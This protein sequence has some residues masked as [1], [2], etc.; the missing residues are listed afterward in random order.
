MRQTDKEP[1][2]F[3]R[4][5]AH[6]SNGRCHLGLHHRDSLSNSFPASSTKRLYFQERLLCLD[7]GH[8]LFHS[9]SWEIMFASDTMK[10]KGNILIL[11][12]EKNMHG[13]LTYTQQRKPYFISS[14]DP[15]RKSQFCAPPPPQA[16]IRLGIWQLN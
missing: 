8:I 10:I 14:P 3:G 7:L 11:I 9:V 2:A 12:L 5:R 6:G 4:L 1:I 13:A 15:N 16:L